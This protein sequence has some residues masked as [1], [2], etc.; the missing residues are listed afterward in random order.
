[1][2]RHTVLLV[3]D[4]FLIA[5]ILEESLESA[6]FDVSLAHNGSEALARVEAEASRYDALVTDIGLGQSPNGWEVAQR[7]RE[8]FPAIAVLYVTACHSR[9]WVS[10]G[11]PDSLVIGKPFTPAYVVKMLS[12][13]LEPGAAAHH[14]N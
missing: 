10:A 11:V 14:L 13:L 12:S 3:E 4:E 8:R 6:G 2:T 9:E 7:T 1:M 5:D